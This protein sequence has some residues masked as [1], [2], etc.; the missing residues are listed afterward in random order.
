M[1][2]TVNLDED[3]AYDRFEQLIAERVAANTEPLFTT[4]TD[5]DELWYRYLNHIPRNKQYYNCNCCRRFIQRY[6]G[7]VTIESGVVTKP[8]LWN[9]DDPKVHSFFGSSTN[10]LWA[11]TKTAKVTGVFLSDE[12]TWGTPVSV[13]NVGTKW[14]HLHGVAKTCAKNP[15][16]TATQQMAEKLEEFKLLKR[17]LENLNRST[18]NT[19]N[20]ILQQGTLY[21]SEKAEEIAKWLITLYDET[22]ILDNEHRDVKLWYT[23]ATAPVGYAHVKNTVLGTLIEDVEVGLPFA[24]ISRR[25]SEKLHPL[26]YMRSTAAPTAGNIA[27]AEMIFEKLGL[28]NSLKRRFARLDE[29]PSEA[30]IWREGNVKKVATP[31][32][33]LFS[34]LLNT[35]TKQMHLPATTMTWVKFARD[36]LPTVSKMELRVPSSGPFYGFLTAEDA[37]APPIIQWD[38]VERRNPFSWY[39]WNGGTIRQ[40]WGLGA[41]AKVLAIM[42]SPATWYQPKSHHGDKMFFV[43]EKCNE[44]LN[45][46]LCLF[47]EMLKS[48][49]REVRSTIEAYSN[50]RTV[51]LAPPGVQYANGIDGWGQTYEVSYEAGVQTI[52]LDRFE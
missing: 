6:G 37:T 52:T 50:S 29:I 14:T 23:V 40:Q 35:P 28:E 45:P 49:L 3:L 19:V 27:A 44:S 16:K 38:S 9:L 30:F 34:E 12:K 25:W 47:S 21:R 41:T 10:Y 17:T 36:V 22:R 18:L 15:L 8:L 33:G 51:P 5:P 48:E 39:F 26:Q 46:K 43:L 13:V 11:Y 42:E 32:P 4:D 7:L 24:T 20:S 1:M 31:K 2:H